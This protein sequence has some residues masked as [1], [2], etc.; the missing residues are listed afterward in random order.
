MKILPVLNIKEFNDRIGDGE[1]YANVFSDHLSTYHASITKPHKHDFY[2][3]VLF[4]E[5]TGV[6]EIDFKSHEIKRGSLFVLRPGQT[7][8]WQLSSDIEGY[9]FFHS[10]SFYQVLF[11][12]NPIN[13]YPIFRANMASPVVHLSE[14]ECL[15]YTIKFRELFE[16]YTSGKWMFYRRFGLL[17]DL[18]YMDLSREFVA[19]ISNYNDLVSKGSEWL[20]RL[21]DLIDQNYTTLK[22]P[23]AYADLLNITTKHLNKMVKTTSG[24]TTSDLINERLLLEAKRLLTYGELTV[25]EIAYELGFEDAS[26]FS[27]F[28]KKKTGESPSN[29]G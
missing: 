12:N 23:S 24:K 29:F 7:H 21:H 11:P 20:Y 4:T 2:L 10:H 1:F 13:D 16:E 26:Y 15:A 9:I 8:Q 5:G 3:V 19:N 14:E 27:R 25:Q 6:H 18:F 17:V 22:R 28:F